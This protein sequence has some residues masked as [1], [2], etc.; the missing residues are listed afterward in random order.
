LDC[1]VKYTPEE[2]MA[3][4][5]VLGMLEE[6]DMRA[7][8]SV[9]MHQHFRGSTKKL[10]LFYQMKRCYIPEDSKLHIHHRE[11]HKSHKSYRIP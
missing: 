8:N 5:R 2:N 11:N 3:W 9:K 10:V 7:F 1:V 6:W 4:I